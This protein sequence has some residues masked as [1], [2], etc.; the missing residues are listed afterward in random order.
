MNRYGLSMAD[1]VH[2]EQEPAADI[3]AFNDPTKKKMKILQLTQE[4]FGLTNLV[5]MQLVSF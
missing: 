3:Y 5:K 1:A 4:N 2:E